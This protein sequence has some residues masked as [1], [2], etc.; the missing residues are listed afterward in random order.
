M[1]LQLTSL[2]GLFLA[3]SAQASFYVCTQENFQG[4]CQNF[5]LPYNECHTFESFFDKKVVSAGP[6]EGSWCTLYANPGCTG[7]E[8]NL[9]FPGLNSLGGWNNKAGSFNCAAV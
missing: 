3:R 5:D 6:D 8:L 9:N 1:K 7:D 2:F 4:I